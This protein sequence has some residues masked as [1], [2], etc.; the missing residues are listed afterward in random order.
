MDF[1][2]IIQ[3]V[4]SVFFSE[5]VLFIILGV[6]LGIFFGAI[7]GLTAVLA[8][9]ILIPLTYGMDTLTGISMLLGAYV[10][11]ISGGCVSAVLLGM[12][13]TPS[14][15]TTVW[16]GFPLAKNGQGRKALGIAI[17]GNMVGSLFGFLVLITIA[18]QLAKISLSFTS[19]EYTLII[20]FTIITVVSLSGESVIKGVLMSV[21]GLSI[22]TIGIDPT[23]GSDRNTFG[24]EF[25][26]SGV[27]PIAAMI[28]LLVVS[29]LFEEL[30]EIHEKTVIPPPV[31]G[32]GGILSFNEFKHSI[33]NFIRSGLIGTGIGILPGI[34]SSLAN[35]VAY[36]QTKKRSKQPDTF[37]KGNIQGIIASETA[38][39]AVVGGALIPLLTLGIP[40]DAITAMLIGGLQIQGLQPGPLLFSEQPLLI[41]GLFVSFFIAVIAMFF[42]MI[43]VGIPFFSRILSV[44][45]DYILPIVIVMSLIGSFSISN[46]ISNVW[47]TIIFGILG[48]IFKKNSYPILPLVITLLLGTMLEKNLRHSLLVS[49]GSLIPFF[50]RPIS[51]VILLLIVG[52]VLFSIRKHI[53]ESN[54]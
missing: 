36:D 22:L 31:K 8:V 39:N 47:I 10:G 16:D 12:P 40:G 1:S 51:V 53:K 37:G 13:G 27:S 20:L 32:G 49:E 50:T 41:L 54:Y 34:G 26:V 28:G 21:L 43:T 42:L 2:L 4:Q 52:T 46:D 38:N 5:T 35:F 11:G 9:V 44:S 7:P 18:P 23:T 15:F 29:K 30:E 25:L 33:A 3:V 24:L 6:V 17:I 14:S 48:Y 19:F 45:K